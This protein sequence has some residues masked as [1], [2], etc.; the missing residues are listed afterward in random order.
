MS[1]EAIDRRVELIKKTSPAIDPRK[2]CLLVI[3]MQEYQVRRDWGCFQFSNLVTPGLLDYFVKEVSE[4]VEPNIKRLL[5]ESRQHEVRISYTMFSSFQKD[6]SDLTRQLKGANEMAEQTVGAP[7][8]PHK[9]DP[10][11][12]IIETLEPRPEDL[13]VIKNTSGVFTATNFDT[14][15]KKM[16]I[17]QL[18][19]CGVVTNM[20]VE[21][22]ARI[23]AELGYDVF[24]IDDACAAWS[25]EVH[26]TALRSF[27]MAFGHVITTDDAISAIQEHP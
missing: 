27:Q 12:A 16:G 19:V 6:G 11:S 22:S 20:C 15:L 21:G 3:D 2:A 5:D 7:V 17:E 10:A 1:Q 8:F 9:D 14:L 18:L 4:R 25:K 24:I 13:I 26:E 23:G